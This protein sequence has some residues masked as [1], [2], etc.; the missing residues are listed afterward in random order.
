MFTVVILSKNSSFLIRSVNA[1]HDDAAVSVS[2]NKLVG[3][4]VGWHGNHYIQIMPTNKQCLLSKH[5]GQSS[6]QDAHC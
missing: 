5:D 3:G 2:K 1:P 6:Q 4:A